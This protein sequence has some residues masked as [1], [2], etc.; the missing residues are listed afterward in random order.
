M[1]KRTNS[2]WSSNQ[3]TPG[4]IW[5]PARSFFPALARQTFGRCQ[6]NARAQHNKVRL[7]VLGFTA[8]ALAGISG[9]RQD[10]H[11]QPKYI[12]LRASEFFPDGRSARLPVANTVG[13]GTRNEDT[14]F[15]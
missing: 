14:Q 3:K 5:T 8:L 12:P 7:L 15:V 1:R 2:F 11:N 13:R 6:I 9:C 10:M 4:L